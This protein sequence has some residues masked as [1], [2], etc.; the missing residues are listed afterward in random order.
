VAGA[1]WLPRS[2]WSAPRW[3]SN[4]FALG[5]ASGSPTHNAVVLWTRLLQP[6][7][8]V[9]EEMLRSYDLRSRRLAAV[10]GVVF[11]TA[12]ATPR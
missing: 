1:L 8:G 7:A 12:A 6:E 11:A 3:D 9:Q 5:V 4:P 2:A 10:S